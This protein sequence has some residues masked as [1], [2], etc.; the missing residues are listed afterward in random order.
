M[1]VMIHRLQDKRRE[2][3]DKA[4]I[5]QRNRNKHNLETR[6][7]AKERNQNNKYVKENRIKCI[8]LLK[9]RDDLNLKVREA[10]EMRQTFNQKARELQ[11]KLNDLQKDL[12]LPR[13]NDIRTIKKEIE[14][15]EFKQMTGVLKPKEE[16]GIVEEIKKLT[17]TIQRHEKEFKQNEKT[18]TILKEKEQ[19]FKE[20][21]ESHRRV[22]E[23]ADKAQQYHEELLE[24]KKKIRFHSKAGDQKQREFVDSKKMAD[25]EHRLHTEYMGLIRDIDKIVGKL[26]RKEK[27]VAK[28]SESQK[29]Q[30]RADDLFEQLRKGGKL[31]T[32]D[33]LEVQKAR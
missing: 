2:L 20:A 23:Y 16:K 22:N 18:R 4:S 1:N 13:G 12:E 17:Q 26:I 21:E 15:L 30:G 29:I 9:M 32:A 7:H 31:S 14:K 6:L 28:K 33:L 11:W 24:S 5:H 3:S 8:E 10:K 27:K 25:Q 19:A